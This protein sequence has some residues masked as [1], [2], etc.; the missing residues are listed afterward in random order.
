M[1]AKSASAAAESARKAI[2]I[3]TLADEFQLACERMDQLLD[4][5]EHDRF[6]EAALRARELASALGEIPYRREPLL[7]Q[8][9]V[10]ELLNKRTQI[11][12]IGK[13][14]MST[15]RG[16]PL[17]PEAKKRLFARGQDTTAA[18]RKNLGII[19][20]EIDRGAKQ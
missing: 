8:D 4:F 9:N 7:A 3:R 16:E 14:L 5:I 12:I 18:L 13:V 2:T 20:G 6:A 17:S 15:N 10:D 11:E 1:Q 19:K